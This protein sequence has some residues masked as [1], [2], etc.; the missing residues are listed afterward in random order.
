MFPGTA[1][2]E[3]NGAATTLRTC[4]RRLE[5][6]VQRTKTF[7][8]EGGVSVDNP[9]ARGDALRGS[10]EATLPVHINH[11]DQLVSDIP[12]GEPKQTIPTMVRNA[13]R[14]EVRALE[15]HPAVTSPATGEAM[16]VR[17]TEVGEDSFRHAVAITPPLLLSST[18]P[19]NNSASCSPTVVNFVAGG[20]SDVDVDRV[21]PALQRERVACC[22][23]HAETTANKGHCQQE[24]RQKPPSA[25][26]AGTPKVS[27]QNALL[28]STT[29]PASCYSP[30]PRSNDCDQRI[31]VHGSVEGSPNVIGSTVYDK[32]KLFY[33]HPGLAPDSN[34]QEGV[35]APSQGSTKSGKAQTRG[36]DRVDF[37]DGSNSA[38]NAR[39]L[40]S[41][42]TNN[43]QQSQRLP[44]S[45]TG[46]SPPSWLPRQDG[47][48]QVPQRLI[49]PEKITTIISPS[50][51][52]FSSFSST[53]GPQA[54]L[55][56]APPPTV[57]A[58]GGRR[59]ER[60]PKLSTAAKAAAGRP[61]AGEPSAIQSIEVTTGL[62]SW[63]E[64]AIS[65]GV[66]L[67][68]DRLRVAERLHWAKEGEQNVRRCIERSVGATVK[69]LPLSFLKKHGYLAEAQVRGLERSRKTVDRQATRVRAY[70]WHRY[71]LFD[72]CGS[73]WFHLIF[74]TALQHSW[75]LIHVTLMPAIT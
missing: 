54:T 35:A 62:G 41:W 44:V 23:Q 26:G 60:S 12:K 49:V 7:P 53:A 18:P 22:R 6:S 13:Q 36:K 65:V 72:K 29:S 43:G 4:P 2:G 27:Q 47:V 14:S 8:C 51:T 33:V 1:D 42:S 28:E 34:V 37:H 15:D 64:E 58:A 71:A 10:D 70:A 73:S 16:V 21:Y 74:V 45:T 9:I 52:P 55:S 5:S 20:I 75:E 68:Q 63:A 69:A 46:I 19:Q 57:A 38:A 61:C 3:Q 31:T 66:L 17:M 25:G 48:P 59:L 50:K 32:H 24:E 30:G 11:D 56:M 40:Q 39:Q 67:E